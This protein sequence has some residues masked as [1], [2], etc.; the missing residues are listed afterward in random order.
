M[1][2]NEFN[3][4]FGT[5]CKYYDKDYTKDNEMMEIYFNEM[6][7][8]NENFSEYIN[9]IFSKFK[10]FP[11]V[12]ELKDLRFKLKEDKGNSINI[13]A[14]ICDCNYCNGSGYRTITEIRYKLPI[15]FLVACDCKNGDNKLYEGSK[16]KE[17]KDR[18]DYA[19]RRF[20]HYI[21][22]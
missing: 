19:V 1:K 10:F 3:T 2:R 6:K 13:N 4:V 14:K 22:V 7:Y 21:P 11:K 15:E 12:A 8:I 17:A 9:Q 20:S 5:I 16:M 18:S